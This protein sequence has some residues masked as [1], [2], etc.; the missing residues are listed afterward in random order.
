MLAGC[1]PGNR[2]DSIHIENIEGLLDAGVGC[3]VC[4]QNELDHK[5]PP[6]KWQRGF[7]HLRPYID[8]MRYIAE[9]KRL[10]RGGPKQEPIMLIHVNMPEAGVC[11]DGFIEKPLKLI[12]KQLMRGRRLYVH[13]FAGHG[14]QGVL[15]SL[16]L[17]A[18]YG[19]PKDRAIAYAQATHDQR[20]DNIGENYK[21]PSNTKQ[22]QQIARLCA[23][24]KADS[25]KS[26]GRMSSN[27]SRVGAKPAARQSDASAVS[28]VP[29]RT[30]PA[31]AA[32]Q[33]KPRPAQP[34][35]PSSGKKRASSNSSNLTSTT[36]DTSASAMAARRR[37][38]KAGRENREPVGVR[39]DRTSNTAPA[40]R[41]RRAPLNTGAMSK[42]DR[43]RT[44]SMPQHPSL[45]PSPYAGKARAA[46]R[47]PPRLGSAGKVLPGIDSNKPSKLVA[48]SQ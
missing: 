23:K 29:R 44:K 10:E 14:R 28:A 15:V 37:L 9:Q 35:K 8:D 6:S 24:A 3:V 39:S 43:T 46:A 4:L 33:S 25:V 48:A 1:Y 13:G 26:K 12:L 19:I 42:K 2:D 47:R 38:A 22:R 45:R 16:L 32:R 17:N 7:P 36:T 41:P 30:G 18:I 5:C 27:N 11:E 34:S 21:C 40:G 31:A 20:E